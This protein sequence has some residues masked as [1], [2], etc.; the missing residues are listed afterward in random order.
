MRIVFLDVDGVLVTGDDPACF[1]DM[2]LID[3]EH[4]NHFHQSCVAALN[5]ITDTTGAKLVISST[6]RGSHKFETL[7]RH[8]IAEGVTGEVYDK[9]PILRDRDHMSVFRGIEIQCWLSRRD[10][11]DIESFVILDDDSDMCHLM[12]R[13]VHTFFRDYK[14][15]GTETGLTMEHAEKAIQLLGEKYVS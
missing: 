4:L 15:D 6:W 3:G 14:R 11:E 7:K 12:R 2:A 5:H 10:H 13:L 1:K 8:L 9:T